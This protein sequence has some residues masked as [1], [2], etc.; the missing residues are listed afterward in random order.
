MGAQECRTSYRVAFEQANSDLHEIYNEYD[1]LQ[2]RKQQIENVLLS[3]QPF[4]E[5][6]STFHQPINQ[7]TPITAPAISTEPA[8]EMPAP[9]ATAVTSDSDALD[10]I[11]HR[12]NRA[13]GL[14]VA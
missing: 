8:Y 14:A 1:W 9:V 12:I 7:P 5:P 3:L 10:P 13:L 6:V 2:V 11:Q 4:L